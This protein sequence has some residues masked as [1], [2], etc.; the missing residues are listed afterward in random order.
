MLKLVRPLALAGRCGRRQCVR[1][2]RPDGSR[3]VGQPI[4][5]GA[6]RARRPRLAPGRTVRVPEVWYGEVCAIMVAPVSVLGTDSMP[7]IWRLKSDGG[8]GE[9]TNAV[10]RGVPKRGYTRGGRAATS[11]TIRNKF[12]EILDR[13][14]PSPHHAMGRKCSDATQQAPHRYSWNVRRD[15]RSGNAR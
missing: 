14:S 15:C 12:F 5:A 9:G 8:R 10:D 6:L 1:Q 11:V 7:A 13:T 4:L 3:L 2:G